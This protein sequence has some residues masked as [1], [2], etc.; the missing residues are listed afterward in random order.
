[1]KIHSL[2]IGVYQ[3]K[4]MCKLPNKD[5]KK[6]SFRHR[7]VTWQKIAKHAL[8]LVNTLVVI[9]KSVFRGHEIFQKSYLT[10]NINYLINEIL[11]QTFFK[12]IKMNLGRKY[13]LYVQKEFIDFW[14][15]LSEF[16]SEF[17]TSVGFGHL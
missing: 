14:S 4:L 15:F 1:M 10:N 2:C 11:I 13:F 16:W 7:Q 9:I 5:F 12:I 3:C 6:T 17:L 8:W